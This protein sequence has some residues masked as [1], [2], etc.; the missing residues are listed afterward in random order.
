M[1][2]PAKIK[3]DIENIQSV[4]KELDSALNSFKESLLTFVLQEIE[5]QKAAAKIVHE[6]DEDAGTVL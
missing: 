2:D 3:A 1:S 4:F 6:Y 5:Q